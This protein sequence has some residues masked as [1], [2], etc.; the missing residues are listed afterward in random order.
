[1]GPHIPPKERIGLATPIHIEP[2]M[3]PEERQR[4][5][6][7][8]HRSDMVDRYISCTCGWMGT[9]QMSEDGWDYG[10]GQLEQWRQHRADV[11]IRR[12]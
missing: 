7:R 8:S 5:L 6:R 12:L 10:P 4:L 9:I 2:P 1:M 3:D 11:G